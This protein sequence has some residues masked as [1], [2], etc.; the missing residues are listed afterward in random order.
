MKD[1]YAENY[2]ILMKVKKTWIN[3]K[4]LPAH[5]LEEL[6]LLKCPYYP[7]QIH[8]FNEILIKI[9]V[10]FFFTEIKQIILKLVWNHKR[11]WIAKTILRNKKEAGSIMLLDFK[12][13]YKAIVIKIVW[14]WHKNRC[15]DNA[16]EER[17]PK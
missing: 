11:P 4:I 14:Y 1:L 8:R 7:K 9:P 16:T 13:Y 6:I 12:W 5:G 3:G 17:A 15:V 2:K 10:A